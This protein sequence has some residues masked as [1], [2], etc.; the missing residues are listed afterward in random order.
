[1]E[2]TGAV[3]H[4][5]DDANDDPR[6]MT[7]IDGEEVRLLVHIEPMDGTEPDPTVE[8]EPAHGGGADS[9]PLAE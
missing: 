7:T 9:P 4:P 6:L 3:E 2:I 8:G 1:M 5:A